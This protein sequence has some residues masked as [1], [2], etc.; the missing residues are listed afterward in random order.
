MAIFSRSGEA[1]FG[2]RG[3]GLSSRYSQIFNP[4]KARVT[5]TWDLHLNEPRSQPLESMVSCVGSGVRSPDED[6][7]HKGWMTHEKKKFKRHL[8]EPI[9][10]SPCWLSVVFN[11]E[12]G[13]V[14]ESGCIALGPAVSGVFERETGTYG[15]HSNSSTFQL[16]SSIKIIDMRNA[17]LYCHEQCSPW[18]CNKTS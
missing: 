5:G 9:L 2:R 6:S 13:A 12:D 11:T 3:E 8:K 18:C 14:E 15:D 10:N 4:S 16:I 7:G 17:I 1:P